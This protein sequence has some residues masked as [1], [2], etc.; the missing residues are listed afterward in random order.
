MASVALTEDVA[1]KDIKLEIGENKE[2]PKIASQL[3]EAKG[4]KLLIALP[5]SS[6]IEV[7]CVQKIGDVQPAER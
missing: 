3:P 7:G 4:Y 1:E 6:L 5:P 2:D